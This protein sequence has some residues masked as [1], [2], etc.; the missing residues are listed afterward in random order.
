LPDEIPGKGSNLNWAGH[1]ARE[2]IDEL[3]ESNP[4][5]FVAV[6]AGLGKLL[7]IE[8]VIGWRGIRYETTNKF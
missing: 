2:F 1:R 6:M 5:D 7:W 4:D 8:N 3:K